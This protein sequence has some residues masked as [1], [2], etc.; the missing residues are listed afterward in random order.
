MHLWEPVAKAEM[1]EGINITM[2]TKNQMLFMLSLPL[3][4]LVLRN[5]LPE[6]QA[7]L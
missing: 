2:I 4:F 6:T 3:N 5:P 1:K 7:Q